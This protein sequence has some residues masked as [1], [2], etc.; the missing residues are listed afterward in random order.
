MKNVTKALLSVLLVLVIGV[1]LISCSGSSSDVPEG[2]QSVTLADQPFCLFVPQNWTPNLSSG[3]SSAYVASTDTILVS[4]RYFAA[5]EG[6]TLESY[7]NDC[8]ER[9]AQTYE[10]FEKTSIDA[11]LLGGEDALKLSFSLEQ[12]QK[13][14]TCFQ[15]STVCRGDVISLYV[16]CDASLYETY[17]EDLNGIVKEFRLV[18][19]ADSTAE[20]VVDKKTPEGMK[21][22]SGE[23]LEYVLYVPTVWVCRSEEGMSEA[24]YPETEKS[25][26]SVTSY[27]PE[28]TMTAKEY[29]AD[30]GEKYKTLFVDYTLLSEETRTVAER[31]AISYSFS[32]ADGERTVCVMQTVFEYNEMIYSITY[33][34][35]EEKFEAHL[36][37]VEQI[38][39][40]FRFR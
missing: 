1:S 30:C 4:A 15:I 2:M 18:E 12:N 14:L 19:R 22:A 31:E 36:G 13:K 35:L 20:P 33:S 6:L 38:L 21:I 34:A 16:Y 24:Y 3:V 40:A 27:V 26:S 11:A 23:D 9:Y 29:F 28:I 5:E 8:A 32:F 25:N 37:D 7:M 10:T 39:N 17:K